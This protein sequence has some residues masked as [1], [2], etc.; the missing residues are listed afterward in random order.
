MNKRPRLDAEDSVYADLL[1]AEPP[2]FVSVDA[3][4]ELISAGPHT[5]G[6]QFPVLAE[7]QAKTVAYR[8][9]CELDTCTVGEKWLLEDSV[10]RLEQLYTCNPCAKLKSIICQRLAVLNLDTL[11]GVAIE[12]CHEAIRLNPANAMAVFT[13]GKCQRKEKDALKLYLQ[14]FS[15]APTALICSEIGDCY[16]RGKGAYIDFEKA[17]TYNLQAAVRGD[18][19]AL[20]NLGWSL[21]NGMLGQFD[22]VLA[23]AFYEL[24][25]QL[26]FVKARH[27]LGYCY[28]DGIGVAADTKRAYEYFLEVMRAGYRRAYYDYALDNPWLSSDTAF[29][30]VSTAQQCTKAQQR[31]VYMYFHGIG[32]PQNIDIAR[33]YCDKL[34][35]SLE[36]V[37]SVRQVPL[38]EGHCTIDYNTNL[39]KCLTVRGLAEVEHHHLKAVFEL[40]IEQQVE[41][42]NVGYKTVNTIPNCNWENSLVRVLHMKSSAF[43][44]LPVSFVKQTR[45][46]E[47][48]L[49]SCSEETVLALL[50]N[51]PKLR[52]LNVSVPAPT[53]AVTVAIQFLC[54]QARRNKAFTTSYLLSQN[55]LNSVDS[56]YWL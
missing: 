44:D 4:K 1:S 43:L 52:V 34:H 5:L 21:Q 17:H 2:E 25:Y 32:T 46:E 22:A 51:N 13:L 23:V 41:E 26:G 19:R 40:A 16:T 55:L 45:L 20:F 10:P 37:T 12:K 28:R 49:N 27:Q 6:A 42:L 39:T 53:P 47:L 7:L 14:A 38:G 8:A 30:H 36:E 56:K 54:L 18:E 31:L 3:L 9:Q 24:S 29:F 15:I 50:I 11:R 33:A 48:T 35:I